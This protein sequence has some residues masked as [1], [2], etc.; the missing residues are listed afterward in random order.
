MGQ[1]V[2]GVVAGRF[3]R[4]ILELGGNNAASS[5]SA[6]IELVVRRHDP[7]P[8]RHSG[9]RCT[10]LRRAIVH[11][12]RIDEVV[13]KMSAAYET[14]P[15]GSPLEHQ[16]WSV[17]DHADRVRSHAGRNRYGTFGRRQ[18]DR[19]RRQLLADEAP[20]AAYVSPTI[21]TMPARRRSS[22]RDIRSTGTS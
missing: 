18:G 10:S 7:S 19:R 13:E 1:Q 16:P 6:D 11:N 17:R 4:S 20:D 12:S 9:Q 21:V 8:R 15:I 3:G 14:L 22:Y 5:P 2:A